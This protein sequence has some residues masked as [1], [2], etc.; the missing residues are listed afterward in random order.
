MYS[1]ILYSLSVFPMGIYQLVPQKEGYVFMPD[2]LRVQILE[3]DRL[4][5]SFEALHV[6]PLLVDRTNTHE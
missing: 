6:Q 5:Q 2:T 3:T 1:W 4:G